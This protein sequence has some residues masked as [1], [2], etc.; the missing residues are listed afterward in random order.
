MDV[1]ASLPS[2]RTPTGGARTFMVAL[3]AAAFVLGGT[4]GYV[5]RGWSSAAS[6]PT[7]THTTN[8]PFVI[9]PVPYSSPAPSPAQPPTL[10]PNG[11]TVPI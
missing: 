11:F 8:H 3:L 2:A 4:G 9:E 1:S 10:D 5:V 7:T 6:T